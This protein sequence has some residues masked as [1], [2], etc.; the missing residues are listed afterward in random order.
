LRTVLMATACVIA[1]M[2]LFIWIVFRIPAN[3]A[4]A[5]IEATDH[6]ALLAACRQAIADRPEYTNDRDPAVTWMDEWVTCERGSKDYYSRLPATLRH[7]DPNWV[8]IGTNQV[9]VSFRGPPARVY[10]RGFAPGATQFGTRQLIDGLW[11]QH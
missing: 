10:V 9:L 4:V 5:K 7:L 2:F 11:I 1:G 3:R 6:A 8:L